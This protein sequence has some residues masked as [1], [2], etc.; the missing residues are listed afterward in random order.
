M[1]CSISLGHRPELRS[2]L[3]CFKSIFRIHT[4]TGNI[5][6]HLL[7]A[8]AFIAIAAYVITR[9]SLEIQVWAAFSVYIYS[10]T[11]YFGFSTVATSFSFLAKLRRDEAKSCPT[12]A[13]SLDSIIGKKVEV[14]LRLFDIFERNRV[15]IFL[16]GSWGSPPTEWGLQWN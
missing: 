15:F 12:D 2:F 3:S 7:G 5:W 1:P 13:S 11:I 4:E 6:T 16:C 14:S 9:P 10:L 8:I